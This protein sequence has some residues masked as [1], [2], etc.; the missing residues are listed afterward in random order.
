MC[1]SPPGASLSPEFGGI[2]A[3]MESEHPSKPL[4]QPLAKPDLDVSASERKANGLSAVGCGAHSLAA[5]RSGGKSS[6][7]ETLPLA[8]S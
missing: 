8:F 2:A 6:I 5:K 4:G 3:G 1:S 7:A